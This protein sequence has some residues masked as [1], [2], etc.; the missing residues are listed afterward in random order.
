MLKV[1][2]C[3]KVNWIVLSEAFINYN[4]NTPCTQAHVKLNILFDFAF[5]YV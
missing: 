1:K 4:L 2:V 5:D 3:N